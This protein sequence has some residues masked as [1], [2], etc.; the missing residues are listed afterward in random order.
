VSAGSAGSLCSLCSLFSLLA[1]AALWKS[2]FGRAHDADFQ[3]FCAAYQGL[4]V[5]TA[6]V[7]TRVRGGSRL[8]LASSKAA[9]G[10]Y[11]GVPLRRGGR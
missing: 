10:G 1:G 7:P 8:V 3:D 9:G 11:P 5:I 4:R 6:V 2:A